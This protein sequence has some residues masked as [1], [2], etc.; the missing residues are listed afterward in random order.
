MQ[1]IR[2]SNG[3]A[4]SVLQCHGQVSIR[5]NVWPVEILIALKKCVCVDSVVS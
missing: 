4:H 2:F 3:T 5:V 1:P